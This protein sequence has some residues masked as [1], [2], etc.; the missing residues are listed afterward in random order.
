MIWW[1]VSVSRQHALCDT[2][3]AALAP[4]GLLVSRFRFTDPTRAGQSAEPVLRDYLRRLERNPD[5]EQVL[6][7]ALYSWLYDH[8]TD[9]ASKRLDRNRA[10]ALVLGLAATPEF[11]RHQEYLHGFADRLRGP[12]WTS[13]TREE[14][15]GI[16]GARF[17]GRR[18]PMPTTT[19]PAST[20][21]SP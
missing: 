19:T 12:D 20:R 13:Q 3:R 11:S 4:D 5:D 16:V 2:I 10:R 1:A 8:T 18:K 14:L 9:R 17:E 7:G 21:S 6:R 15:L